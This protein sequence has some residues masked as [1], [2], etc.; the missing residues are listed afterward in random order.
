MFSTQL[1]RMPYSFPRSSLLALRARARGKYLYWNARNNMKTK[2]YIPALWLKALLVEVF[3]PGALALSPGDLWSSSW[4]TLPGMTG[5]EP[6]IVRNCIKNIFIEVHR[7]A[8]K[9]TI[10]KDEWVEFLHTKVCEASP[11]CEVCW[12][13]NFI[14]R[15]KSSLTGTRSGEK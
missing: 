1:G 5:W 2:Y 7:C 12:Y 6:N 3:C 13:L 8:E 14:W 11:A 9:G 15:I 10:D 4:C